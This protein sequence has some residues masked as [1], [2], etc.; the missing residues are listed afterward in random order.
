MQQYQI[1]LLQELSFNN[2]QWLF[3][4]HRKKIYVIFIVAEEWKL[5]WKA[6]VLITMTHKYIWY[7]L[8]GV[9]GWG[10]SLLLPAASEL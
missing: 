4:L 5:H 3:V 6:T 1:L 7:E 9:A 8:Y 10:E 2:K